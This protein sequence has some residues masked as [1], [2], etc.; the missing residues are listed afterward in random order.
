MG[1]E[2]DTEGARDGDVAGALDPLTPG[3]SRIV[4]C[5]AVGA[6]NAGCMCRAGARASA[7]EAKRGIGICCFFWP[8][9]APGRACIRF[10]C[11][12]QRFSS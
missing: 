1:G 5:R 10:A 11:L 2:D 7:S 4:W 6:T 3:I 8:L 12:R 9:W